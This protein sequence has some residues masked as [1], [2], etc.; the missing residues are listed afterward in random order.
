MLKTGKY[1]ENANKTKKVDIE[2]QRRH[3]YHRINLLTYLVLFAL[4]ICFPI[5]NILK[6]LYI[7]SSK[8]KIFKKT[9]K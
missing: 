2:H 6:V 4:S 1:R 3:V 7:K 5:S 8:I 9:Q